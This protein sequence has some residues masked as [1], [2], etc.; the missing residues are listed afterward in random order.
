ML[1]A[2]T[3]YD[4]K[5]SSL[6]TWCLGKSVLLA[7]NFELLPDYFTECPLLLALGANS[8]GTI[9]YSSS[10]HLRFSL[11]R[12]YFRH[13]LKFFL[14]VFVFLFDALLCFQYPLCY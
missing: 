9:P 14:D 1:L 13:V 7:V 12:S 3:S 11:Q 10:W 2:F 4:N 5:I 6:P 8:L